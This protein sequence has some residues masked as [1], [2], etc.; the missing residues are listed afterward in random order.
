MGTRDDTPDTAEGH[1][2]PLEEAALAVGMPP[3][4]LARVVV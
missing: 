1:R 4:A 3:L 2:H